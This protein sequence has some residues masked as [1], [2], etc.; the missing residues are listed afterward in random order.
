M[1]IYHGLRWLWKST[2]SRSRRY[3]QIIRSNLWHTRTSAVSLSMS[4]VIDHL[5]WLTGLLRGWDDLFNKCSENLNSLTAMK[6][7]PYY[8]G[9]KYF[10]VTAS[11]ADICIAIKSS[12]K[13]YRRY[14]TSIP[15]Y[16]LFTHCLLGWC[17]G[18]KA[19]PNPCAIR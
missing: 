16:P 3:G 11:G 7:S 10:E 15:L 8:K 17:L 19:Q 2:S 18:R 13:R 9:T 6:L 1:L 12:R 4:I 5:S 14:H